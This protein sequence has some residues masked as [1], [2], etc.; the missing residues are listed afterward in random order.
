MGKPRLASD[1]HTMLRGPLVLFLVALA[2]CATFR[3]T[4]EQQ[5]ARAAWESCPKAAN[6]ALT[7]IDPNGLIHHRAVS[8]QSGARTLA[9]CLRSRG[10]SVSSEPV[11][12]SSP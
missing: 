3:P 10:A 2:G 8:S 7:S 11:L 1:G 4:T 12:A 5:V 6:L 9:E